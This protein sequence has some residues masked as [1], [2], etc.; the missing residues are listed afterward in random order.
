MKQMK[1]LDLFN[2]ASV[3]SEDFTTDDYETPNHVARAMANLALPSDHRILEP[4]AGTGQIAKYLPCDRYVVCNEIKKS[5]YSQG[6]ETVRANWW[7]N[8][9]FFADAFVEDCYDLII[10]NPPF[11]LCMEAVE[12]SLELLNPD[13]PNARI[14]F[15][16]P[17]DTFSS[18][19]RSLRFSRLNAYIK[20]V[21]LIPGRVDY[22]KDGKPMS[23]HQ[24]LVDG[25][26]RFTSGGK[27]V[28]MSGRQVSDAVWCIY[29]G[30]NDQYVSFLEC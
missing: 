1:Q 25:I 21:H 6:R 26:P 4:F 7:F 5:R 20:Q 17:I 11:S 30:R 29:P 18:R 3:V 15:L 16:M 28:M 13:N 9:D 27:P 24:K 19:E 8:E 22:L 10:S 23:K 12:R 2:T 14:L